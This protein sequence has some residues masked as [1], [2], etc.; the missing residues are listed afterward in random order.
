MSDRTL[1]ARSRA[2]A[3]LGRDL[4]GR[5]WLPAT[6]GNLSARL[7]SGN[8]LITASGRH[9]GRLGRDDVLEVDLEGRPVSSGSRPSAETLLHM[10]RYR[11][12]PKIEAVFH[13]HSPY[14]TLVS[15]RPEP[16]LVLR[17]YELLKAFP[18]IDTHEAE[19]RVPV[20]PNDQDMARLSAR[21]DA[22][23]ATG[24]FYGYLIAGHGLYAWGDS[25]DDAMRHIEAFDFL[26][27]CTILSR[28]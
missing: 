26:F 3:R 24:P 15:L 14:A 20:F 10:A 7:E 22:W 25:L 17:G 27:H 11:A 4:H 16:E 9:K 21:V 8:I 18:G 23:R 19:L 12:D 13:V 5:G 1:P 6:S 28:T 2:L